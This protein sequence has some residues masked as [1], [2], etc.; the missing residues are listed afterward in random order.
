MEGKGEEGRGAR[1]G[2]ALRA[3]KERQRKREG[4]RKRGE[5]KGKKENGA[6]YFLLG[7]YGSENL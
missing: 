7:E 6:L 2:R 3:G 4:R 1:Q 5:G